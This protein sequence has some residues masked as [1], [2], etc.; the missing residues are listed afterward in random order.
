LVTFQIS[1]DVAQKAAPNAE[2]QR[3]ILARMRSFGMTPV[4]PAFAG[5]VPAALAAQRP[6]LNIVRYAS[7]SLADP[8]SNAIKN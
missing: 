7:Q 1:A 2:L 4:F 8:C 5:F 6:E 3:K